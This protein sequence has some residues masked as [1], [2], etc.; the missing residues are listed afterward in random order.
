MS[1]GTR[2]CHGS[3]LID[4]SL[5]LHV[6]I[7]IFYFGFILFTIYREMI[8]FTSVKQA[9]LL[10]PL[11]A[12]RISSRT[13]LITSIPDSYNNEEALLKIFD[14]VKHIWIN[15]DVSELDELVNERTKVTL[16]LEAAQVKLIKT[17]DKARRKSG[18]TTAD[19]E[20]VEA[21]NASG[22][23]AAKYIAKKDRPT[24]KLK[25]LVG[26]TV[27]TI[28]WCRSR[29][30]ELNPKIEELQAKHRHGD[31]KFLNTAFIE[32]TSQKAAQAASQ[33]LA[34]H[35]PLHMAPR[36]IG[37]DPSEVIWSNMRLQWWERLVKFAAT[38][39]FVVAL[40]IFWSIPVAVV[41]LVSK[42]D[43]LTEKL[44]WLG[45]IN[46]IPKPILGVITGLLPAV[47]LAILMALL[48]IILRL[49]ARIQ[50]GVSLS[51]V[52][53][54]TQNM[55]F[56]FQVVQV[57]L[58]TTLSSSASAAFKDIADNPS[59]TPTV[60]ASSIPKASNFYIS[61]ML[62][63]GLSISAGTLLQIAGLILYKLLGMLL[64]NSP[65]KQFNRW[66]ALSGLGWGTV[67]PVYTLIT[68][69]AI[70]YSII[71][72]LVL[73]F[74][75]IAL[76]LLYFAYRYNILFVYNTNIDTKGA[77]Y[78]RALYHTLT[79][80]YLAE[81]CLVGLFGASKAFGPMVI[82]IIFLVFT[83]L[84]Q[85][86]LSNSVQPLLDFLPR[87]VGAENTDPTGDHP[88]DS[89]LADESAL[90]GTDSANTHALPTPA[91]GFLTRF[92]HPEKY[93]SYEIVKGVIPPH[94]GYAYTQE[95][96]LDAYFH[97]AVT[98]TPMTIWLP[99][100][101]AGVSAQ[102]VAHNQEV[103]PSSDEGAVVDGKGKVRR[104]EEFTAPPGWEPAVKY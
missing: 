46:D 55:Y 49:M 99:R 57:F 98:S 38:T 47:A 14:N 13:V 70:T 18:V 66:A 62:V 11:Y 44:P 60:L 91:P 34:H 50:G 28:D 51:Q 84:F 92:L 76:T 31:C 32:F 48:P 67:F 85:I 9:Y 100:D 54:K 4:C 93:S 25:P 52:E 74:G 21:A 95:Q 53:L 6:F 7:G 63:Q 64:D 37:I 80:I 56:A 45:F 8:Y 77:V 24:H 35:Q 22:S 10:S 78:P 41:G 83:V 27:D 72:P 88:T 42:V 96:Q 12:S 59:S 16:K 75:T 101:P 82:Q 29:L 33:T 19:D 2:N 102:E 61:Y 73:Y 26:E 3:L 39:A 5:Y 69:I 65:R 17:V 81:I 58:V 36:V 40:V 15:Q 20:D 23:V 68:V 104:V 30:A 79:G 87:S 94:L 1:L 90:K 43:Y 71:A 86:T 97:P 103:V 89:P